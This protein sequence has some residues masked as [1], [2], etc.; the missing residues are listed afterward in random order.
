MPRN[1]EELLQR[2][3]RVSAEVMMRIP[4][5]APRHLQIGQVCFAVHADWDERILNSILDLFREEAALARFPNKRF[6]HEIPKTL[7]SKSR[8]P[9]H[10]GSAIDG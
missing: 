9:S 7:T 3:V 8:I 1:Q 10:D 4:A 6:R 2:E 5:K